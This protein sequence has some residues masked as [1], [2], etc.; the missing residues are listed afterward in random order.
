M[1]LP[2]SARQ[3]QAGRM[4]LALKAAEAKLKQTTPPASK[5][6]GN[7]KQPLSVIARRKSMLTGTGPP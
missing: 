7:T 2:A 3:V 5:V 4:E 6:A 1:G